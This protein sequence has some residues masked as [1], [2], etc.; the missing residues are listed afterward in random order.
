MR[1]AKHTESVIHK[2]RRHLAKKILGAT[3]IAWALI[4]LWQMDGPAIPHREQRTI[5]CTCRLEMLTDSGPVSI[6][7]IHSKWTPEDS[8][9]AAWERQLAEGG[10]P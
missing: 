6:Y 5:P 2:P 10:T 8:A 1:K 9:Q 4:V 3:I 7:E